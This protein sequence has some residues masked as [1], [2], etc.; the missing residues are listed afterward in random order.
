MSYLRPYH[1]STGIYLVLRGNF[2]EP[3]LWHG[4]A[5]CRRI[6]EIT[7]TSHEAFAILGWCIQHEKALFLK[8]T[9]PIRN[10]RIPPID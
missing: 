8:C 6:H 3:P 1:K 10:A 9:W 2:A 5:I 4:I 7:L